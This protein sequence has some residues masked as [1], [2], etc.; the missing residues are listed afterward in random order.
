MQLC[1]EHLH[2]AVQEH[3]HAGSST[4][5]GEVEVVTLR[6]SGSHGGEPATKA[7]SAQKRP[8][9]LAAVCI[10]LHAQLPLAAVSAAAQQLVA[11]PYVQLAENSAEQLVLLFEQYPQAQLPECTSAADI[12]ARTKQDVEVQ[13]SRSSVT[14]ILKRKGMQH[15]SPK[16]VPLLTAMQKA[17]RIKFA[18]AAL[19]TE[20]VSWHRV[21]ITDSKYFK[22]YAMGKPAGRWCTPASR[23]T[24]ARPKTSIAVHAYMGCCRH[25]TTTLRFVTGRNKQ[26]SKHVNPKTKRLHTGVGQ[27]EYHAVIQEHWVPEGNRLF[28]QAGKW[29]DNWQLQQDNAAAA[30][31]IWHTSLP[32]C[33]DQAIS[34]MLLLLIQQ[35]FRDIESIVTQIV[36]SESPLLGQHKACLGWCHAWLCSNLR[37]LQSRFA[38]LLATDL[39]ACLHRSL[40]G[41]TASWGARSGDQS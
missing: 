28:Q 31:K 30:R 6:A 4:G 1:L 23:G 34:L 36:R 5:A 12:A 7:D 32:M 33:Q 15:L 11:L 8:C 37:A 25:G 2:Q 14:R 29:A 17:A 18:R 27:D 24:V 10:A 26:A 19:R 41:K 3:E 40:E 35:L 9:G 39:A 20:V 13:L 38:T 16:V 22:L 21:L